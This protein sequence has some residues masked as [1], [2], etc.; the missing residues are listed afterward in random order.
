M[1]V[2]TEMLLVKSLFW[3]VW[4]LLAL[5]GM[6]IEPK[7]C[8]MSGSYL[9]QASMRNNKKDTESVFVNQGSC[10]NHSQET[11]N[12]QQQCVFPE[13]MSWLLRIICRPHCRLFQMLL[14]LC[15]E[16][17]F[18]SKQKTWWN[19]KMYKKQRQTKKQWEK[20]GKQTARQKEFCFYIY[21]IILMII[22][23]YYIIIL[24][25]HIPSA[26]CMFLSTPIM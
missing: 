20:E 10:T 25:H 4:Q 12:C 1:Q 16:I 14:F 7:T 13:T 3:D 26:M 19:S 11:D 21:Y 5:P 8:L 23:Y 24:F 9:E 6:E 18:W 17:V 15:C 22:Y 2:C